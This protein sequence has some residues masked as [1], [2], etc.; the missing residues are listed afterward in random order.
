MFRKILRLLVKLAL[1]ILG[2]LIYFIS[3]LIPKNKNLWI[4]GAWFGEKYA[5]NSKYLFEYVN[6]NH[7]EIE[8]VWLTQNKITLELIKEKG[9]KA[10][11]TYSLKGLWLSMRAKVGILSTAMV[12]I[13]KYVAAN[14]KIVQLWHGIP[15][16]KIMYNDKITFKHPTLFEKMI[17]KVFPFLQKD[18][19]YTN[20]LLIATSD[21]VRQRISSAFKSDIKNVKITGLPRNDAFFLP[22]AEKVPILESILDLK[23]RGIKV[24]IC[25]PTHRKEGKSSLACFFSKDLSYINSELHN[26]KVTLLVKLHFYHLRNT[27]IFLY[28]Y[29]NIIFLKDDD[30]KQDIYSIL[31]KTDFL[32]TDYSSIYFDYLLLDIP[33]IFT[34]FD[35]E[36]Y[37]KN[38]RE[39][40]YNYEEIT[41]GP[42]AKNWSEVLQCI[43][44]TIEYPDKYKDQR[45]KLRKL[46]HKYRDGNSSQ[47]VFNEIVKMIS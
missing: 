4:F 35:I 3:S 43:K 37:I 9:Y 13:N 40:Y 46:F 20:V 34:P 15:F 7:T 27:N 41:P 29:S 32:I 17:L 22:M 2:D 30:I 44:E 16:K 39:F 33:I 18:V 23:K 11:L 42:K 25:M 28:K 6:K 12:D 38:D 36:N 31:P 14:M 8:A 45:A 21:E 5:D 26:Y 19:N 47:R 1:Y 24:G 10:Y